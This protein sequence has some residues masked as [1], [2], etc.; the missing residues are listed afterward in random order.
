MRSVLQGRG[1]PARCVLEVPFLSPVWEG[2]RR[3]AAAENGIKQKT[4]VYTAFCT[5]KPS[6]LEIVRPSAPYAKE[7][8]PSA[9]A[10]VR[11][12]PCGEAQP[13][14]SMNRV[15]AAMRNT[16]AI[17]TRDTTYVAAFSRAAL[18]L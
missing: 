7:S 9:P 10:D 14:S 1:G 11:V 18:R 5:H 4:T 8:P 3:A 15:T 6:F 17:A 2:A 13:K 12:L 16:A